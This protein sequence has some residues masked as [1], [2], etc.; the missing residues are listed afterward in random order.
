M[1]AFFTSGLEVATRPA[2]NLYNIPYPALLHFLSTGMSR[3]YPS[4]FLPCHEY[5]VSNHNHHLLPSSSPLQSIMNF[6]QLV[7]AKLSNWDFNLP[8]LNCPD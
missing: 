3:K 2:S 6:L 5:C 4:P 1:R 7:E 8:L